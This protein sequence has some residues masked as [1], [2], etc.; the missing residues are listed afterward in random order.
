MKILVTAYSLKTGSLKTSALVANWHVAD[1]I[2]KK[3]RNQE[4]KDGNHL[5]DQS[6]WLLIS[7]NSINR[8]VR[9]G[10]FLELAGSLPTIRLDF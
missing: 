8:N 7:W 9:M 6:D 3:E 4:T 10:S 1:A 2:C 5:L